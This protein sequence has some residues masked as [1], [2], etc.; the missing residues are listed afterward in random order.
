M[1]R[2]SVFKSMFTLALSM[3]LL[4]SLAVTASAATITI[5]KSGEGVRI[6]D[7]GR[8]VAY[9]IFKGTVDS[10]KKNELK[11]ITWGDG[12]QSTELVNELGESSTFAAEFKKY[13]DEYGSSISEADLV[14]EFLAHH[15]DF[16][17]E[18]ARIAAKYKNGGGTASEYKDTEGWVINS[19]ADGYYLVV[20]TYSSTGAKPDDVVSSYILQV[21]G[22]AT[23]TVKSTIPTVE[24]KVQGQTGWLTE[25]NK[26]VTF[27]LIGTVTEYIDEYETYAYTFT[28]TLSKGLTLD[29]SALNALTVEIDGKSVAKS[30]DTYTAQ[31]TSGPGDGETTLTVKF[32]NLKAVAKSVGAT[33]NKDSKIVV[34]YTAKQN[35]DAVVGNDGNPNNV[36]LKYS[37]NP[38]DSGEGESVT[39]EVKTYTLG[40]DI[41]KQNEDS[42]TLSGA[43]F[44]LKD[45][46][47]NYAELEEVKDGE[48]IKYYV[49]KEWKTSDAESGTSL[50]TDSDG[51]FH[52]HGLAAG[53]YTLE[54]TKAPDE[55]E[56]MKDVTFTIIGGTDATEAALGT[57]SLT[58]AESREDVDITEDMTAG[59]GT[60][61]LTLTNYKAPILPNTGGIGAKIVYVVSGLAVLIGVCVVLMALKKRKD[62]KA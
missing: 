60:A 15:S 23:V 34:T 57:V 56:K 33:L 4:L 6:G 49:A 39:K 61:T 38:Y 29:E 19:L 12:V 21:S 52:I 54:E 9:Q 11:G 16:A 27:T 47:G 25:T 45:R 8:F 18:F 32:A 2:Q 53:T 59:N 20:D 3:A 13:K 62:D 40:L 48:T 41:V 35:K 7:E 50:T 24:K 37:N 30:P 46:D 26:E 22:N 43:E 14:A 17:E 55:Y 1:K 42:V 10:S 58:L 44:K 51:V 36:T 5:N 31:T 28:D